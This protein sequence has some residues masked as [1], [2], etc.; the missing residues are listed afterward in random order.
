MQVSVTFYPEEKQYADALY[1]YRT[2]L[3]YGVAF[4]KK[5]AMVKKG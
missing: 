2:I 4:Y 3:R 5:S 1:G